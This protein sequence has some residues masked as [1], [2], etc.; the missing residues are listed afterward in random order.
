MQGDNHRND[1]ISMWSCKC[2][3]TAKESCD[4]DNPLKRIN[5]LSTNLTK[6]SNILKQFVGSLPT[7]CLSVFD[8]FV[9]LALQKLNA[10]TVD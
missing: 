1:G 4:N 8:H 6:W 2:K 3:K 9:G 10:T 5:P 7:N